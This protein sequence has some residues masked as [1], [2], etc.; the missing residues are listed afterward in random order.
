MLAL[1]LRSAQAELKL[2]ATTRP[3]PVRTSPDATRAAVHLKLLRARKPN[4]TPPVTTLG[5]QHKITPFPALQR[6]R[7]CL[8]LGGTLRDFQRPPCRFPASTGKS[9]FE[10]IAVWFGT[11]RSAPGLLRLGSWNVV[12]NV[13]RPLSRKGLLCH[14]KQPR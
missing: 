10:Q 4:F 7:S 1:I 2:R 12:V 14:Q 13:Q 5:E 8:Y 3:Q 6:L 11:D 9:N